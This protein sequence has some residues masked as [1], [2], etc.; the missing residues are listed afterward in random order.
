MLGHFCA[1]VATGTDVDEHL[2]KVVSKAL[3]K[4]EAFAHS[5]ILIALKKTPGGVLPA[6]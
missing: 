1:A 4:L 6:T 3:S 2:G 5:P